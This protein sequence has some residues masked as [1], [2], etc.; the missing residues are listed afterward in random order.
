MSSGSPASSAGLHR[1]ST[2]SSGSS[3]PVSKSPASG[4]P[5]CAASPAARMMSL[6]SPGVMSSEP[7]LKAR[8]ALG[9]VI[10][11]TTVWRIRRRAMSPSRST[12]ASSARATSLTRGA[13]RWLHQGTTP[14]R[15]IRSA[16]S[17]LFQTC[18]STSAGRPS[19]W[20]LQAA[21]LPAL[22]PPQTRLSTQPTARASGSAPKP[23][24][25]M[26]TAEAI[27]AGSRSTGA[28]TRMSSAS[29]AF[30]IAALIRCE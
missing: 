23:R 5:P 13:P 30:I 9:M 3:P 22:P 19:P 27:S 6:R 21:G 17:A 11:Q 24:A 25:A 28:A 12:V 14:S 10:A 18:T 15:R 2:P 16:S 8:M 4:M 26:A 7:G 29:S 1:V 20:P